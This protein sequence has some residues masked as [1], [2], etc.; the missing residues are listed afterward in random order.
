MVART[1]IHGAYGIGAAAG[2]AASIAS[3]AFYLVRRR[4]GERGA[5]S[6]GGEG[7]RTRD[8]CVTLTRCFLS[9]TYF[10]PGIERVVCVCVCVRERTIPARSIVQR[11]RSTHA[12]M[13]DTWNLHAGGRCETDAQVPA[14][15][16][17]QQL[18]LPLRRRRPGD[19][20][21]GGGRRRVG[22][23]GRDWV[24]GSFNTT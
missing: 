4:S 3:S 9:N 6:G 13:M 21:P 5:G 20:L 17:P 19:E 15:S 11:T 14:E 16:L 10:P 7:C 2:M 24:H 12:Y 22:G 8:V 23:G 18:V 1:L